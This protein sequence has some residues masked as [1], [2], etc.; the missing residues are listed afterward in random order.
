VH[1][2]VAQHVENGTDS[3]SFGVGQLNSVPFGAVLIADLHAHMEQQFARIA[4]DRVATVGIEAEPRWSMTT[5]C[6]SGINVASGA[7]FD[8]HS[9]SPERPLGFSEQTINRLNL[10]PT[11]TGIIPTTGICAGR[12]QY[13][14]FMSV[15]G[16]G[17][18]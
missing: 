10:V 13:V 7:V 5:C 15:R 3:W 9:G 6:A 1:T 4:R 16:M 14:N 8:I 17:Q 12:T 18:Q 2:H 11:E